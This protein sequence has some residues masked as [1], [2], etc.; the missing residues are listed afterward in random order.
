MTGAPP[1][2][3]DFTLDIPALPSLAQAPGW[4]SPCGRAVLYN[5]DCLPLLGKLKFNSIV[6]DPPYGINY[7]KGNGGLGFHRTGTVTNTKPIYGDDKEF[8]P[9]PLFQCGK[10]RRFG[11]SDTAIVLF[12]ANHYCQKIP[13]EGQWL[14]WDKCC[15]QGA[16]N[17]FVDA[18]FI[19][20]NRRNA[21]CIYR[22]F[23]AG[24]LRAG[25]DN[26]GKSKRMHPSQKPVE[27]MMWLLESARIGLGK[28]VLDP[29]MG[30]G[31]TGVA[32]LRTGRKFIG[33]EIDPEY[34][35]F[36]RARIEKEL[37][38]LR[39]FF[40]EPNHVLGDSNREVK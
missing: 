19:W 35:A 13:H 2:T 16:A 11:T 29:Y 31:T 34:F 20:M 7:T 8:D 18:E 40:E 10:R 14:V 12:G 36:A 38:Q 26:Q 3:S 5:A 4:A 17:S 9:S 39:M 27:L 24:G 30:T 23:W 33:V 1:T 37:E 22:H 25:E 21:R 6:T 32:C 15:G 28:T